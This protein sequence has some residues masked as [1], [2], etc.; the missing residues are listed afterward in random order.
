MS[1][2]TPEERYVDA[3][4]LA[5]LMDVSVTTIKRW[6][7]DGMPSQTWG[8]RVRRYRPSEAMQWAARR[9]RVGGRERTVNAPREPR[10][11]E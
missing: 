3:R 10:S 2:V 8:M 4:R 9:S 6:T 11:K 1:V 5:E 7:A